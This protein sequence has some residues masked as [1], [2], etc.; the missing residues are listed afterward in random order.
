MFFYLH[1]C[2]IIPG[3]RSDHSAVLPKLQINFDN[4][5]CH[6]YWKFN[7]TLLKDVEYVKK[8][9]NIIN[10]NLDRYSL[11]DNNNNNKMV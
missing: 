1:N 6:G 3:N 10:D 7:N 8:V 11:V 5:K 4:K 9:K 2:E